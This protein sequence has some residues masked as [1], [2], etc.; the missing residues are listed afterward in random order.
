MRFRATP[1]RRRRAA[2]LTLLSFLPAVGLIV[3]TGPS[4]SAHGAPMGP[5]SRTFLCWQHAVTQ[6]GQID[7]TNPA[8]RAALQ[9]GGATAYYNWFAVLQ[10]NAQGRTRGFIPDGQL[11]SGGSGAYDFSG[12]DLARDDWPYTHVTAG[13]PFRFSYNVWAHHPGTFH[14]YV[15]KD[16][17]DPTKP[18][19]WDDLEDQ[20]FHS[21][22][23]PPWTGSVGTVE[24]EYYWTANLPRNKSGKHIIYMH[25]VRSDSPENFYSCSD[26]V[27]DGGSGEVTIPGVG[28]GGP[29]GN[30]VGGGS[31]GNDGGNGGNGGDDGGTSAGNDGG[32]NGGNGDVGGDNGGSGPIGAE[33]TAQR[34]I[35]S[36]WSGGYQ[37]EV[38]VT[39]ALDVALTGWTASWTQPAGSTLDQVWSGTSMVHGDH[40]MVQNASWNGSLAPGASTTFG[41]IASGNP[42]AES[43]VDCGGFRAGTQAGDQHAAHAQHVGH[44]AHAEPAGKTL[45]D[46]VVSGARSLISA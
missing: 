22:T 19:T 27:F 40:V 9:Q 37:A 23:D 26:V 21:V 33:C 35:V 32:E 14:L 30:T 17:Y 39:N 15:T 45:L 16:D 31:G 12:F 18:L 43:T 11:C 2:L 5:G 38:T 28:S 8:C 44:T 34:T 7:P 42:P 13:A 36:S 4:A 29:G 46:R 24:A 1:G 6:S 20:P 3:F 41:Y 10:S 25:W